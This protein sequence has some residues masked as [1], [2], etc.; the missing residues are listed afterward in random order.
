MAKPAQELRHCC[1]YFTANSLSRIITRKAEDAFRPTGLSPSHA[2]LVMLVVENPGIVP[3]ELSQYLSLA[4]STVTRL[5]D[6]LQIKGF[7]ERNTKGKAVM[8]FPTPE[9]EEIYPEI[10]A[11]WKRLYETYTRELGPI[12]GDRLTRR[13]DQAA[14]KL[15]GS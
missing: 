2:F 10:T 12:D 11:A 4:P 13:I 9:A 7:L 6:S 3:T 5:V 1:L 8:I 14:Q 15:S